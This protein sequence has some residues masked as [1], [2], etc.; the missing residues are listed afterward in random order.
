M[1]VQ[2][3]GLP[4]SPNT[5]F[6]LGFTIQN[7]KEHLNNMIKKLPWKEFKNSKRMVCSLGKDYPYSGQVATAHPLSTYKPLEKLLERVNKELGTN[8]NSVLLNY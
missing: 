2:S 1:K 4:K 3:I 6:V 7:T 8:Y 5:G